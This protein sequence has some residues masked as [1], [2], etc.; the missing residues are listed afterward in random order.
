MNEARILLCS[1]SEFSVDDVDD[2]GVVGGSRYELTGRQ[3]AVSVTVQLD[4]QHPRTWLR[5]LVHA[6]QLPQTVNS[7]PTQY[8]LHQD[9]LKCKKI[10]DKQ[11]HL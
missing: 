4:H 3:F 6:R 9:A 8:P 2:G 5:S 1:L 11:K 10:N 7:L